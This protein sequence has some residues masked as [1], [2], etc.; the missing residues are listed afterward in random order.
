M[1]TEL[2]GVAVMGR[3]PRPGR[4]KTRLAQ[5]VG[6][7][8]AAQLYA[9]FLADVFALVDAAVDTGARRVFSCALAD[10][11]TLAEA[12]A[13]VPHEG[14]Q[15]VAQPA[16][17]LGEKIRFS[18]QAAGEGG[19]ALVIGS[20]APTMAMER[21]R[22]ALA[23]LAMTDAVMGPTADGGYDLIGLSG[24]HVALFEGI[25]WSTDAVAEC[26]RR[27]AERA[28]LRLTTLTVG[29]DI[30]HYEDLRRALADARA[31]GAVAR[32][33]AAAIVA[34]CPDLDDG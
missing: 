23:A 3:I 5:T 24:E 13:L 12:T 21:L 19:A 22:A 7:A 15:V 20:D 16:G 25:P 33:S 32:R 28:G 10:D 8:A 30:D 14:W 4:V 18:W 9:A 6:D 11:E 2:T 27:A 1:P 31:P 17:G 29:Y 26:T 34:V